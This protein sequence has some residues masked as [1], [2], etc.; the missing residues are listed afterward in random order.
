VRLLKKD[1]RDPPALPARLQPPAG[2]PEQCQPLVEPPNLLANYETF[3]REVMD[4]WGRGEA[5]AGL[6]RLW[7]SLMNAPRLSGRGGGQR[8]RPPRARA[9]PSRAQAPPSGSRPRRVRCTTRS[10]CRWGCASAQTSHR[11]V[12]MVMLVMIHKRSLPLISDDGVSGDDTQ[13]R[14]ARV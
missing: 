3:V 1:A 6:W 2:L 11:L 5:A 9:R 13:E 4:D 10:A 8:P 14:G 12:M 7:R